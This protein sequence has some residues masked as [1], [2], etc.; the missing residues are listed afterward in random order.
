MVDG[1]ELRALMPNF[2]WEGISVGGTFVGI[3]VGSTRLGG[4]AIVVSGDGTNVATCSTGSGLVLTMGS[5]L[6][7][8]TRMPTRRITIIGKLQMTVF[9]LCKVI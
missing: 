9:V 3:E 1:T 7:Q 6:A 2:G 4:R 8:A 5:S